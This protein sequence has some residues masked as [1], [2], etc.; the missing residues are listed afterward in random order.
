MSSNG[1]P[2][3]PFEIGATY[4]RVKNASQ[5][6]TTTC[7]LCLG[8][9]FVVVLDAAG[10]SYA[11]E[12]ENCRSGYQSTGRTS[13]WR[14]VAAVEPFVVASVHSYR[15]GKWT[16]RDAQDGSID[17]EYLYETEALAMARAE[18]QVEALHENNWGQRK[19]RRENALQR[20]V[21]TAAYHRTQVRT[22]REKLAWHESKLR[23]N[24]V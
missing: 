24:N 22:L 23:R 12:C 5:Q 8:N 17:F 10:A 13:E 18:A 20:A 2:D 9:L 15:D 21:S 3:A 14:G 11:V 4:W 7:D 1:L 6:V 19:R 16:V